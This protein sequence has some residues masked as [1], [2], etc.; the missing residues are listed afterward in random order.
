MIGVLTVA[1]YPNWFIGGARD[2]FA[3]YLEHY[4]GQHRLRFLQIG[5]FTGDAS[6]WLLD[7][8]LTDQ[9]STL[10]DVDT[11]Q[12]SP[13]ESVHMAMDFEDVY[14]TYKAKVEPYKNVRSM[15]MRSDEFFKNQKP[16]TFDF[17][18]IDGDHTA[19]ATYN[20]AVGAWNCLMPNGIIA[21]DDYR[22]GDGLADQSLAPKPGIDR[23]LEEYIGDYVLLMK[24]YQ[25]WIRRNA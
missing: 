24:G 11:W 10:I 18:Y 12:G 8:I 23:F 7:N 5:V 4:R 25:V 15:R 1:E 2:N 9:S 16:M 13:D 22:W 20:D 21:F 3:T 14:A 6:V 19:E 17:I